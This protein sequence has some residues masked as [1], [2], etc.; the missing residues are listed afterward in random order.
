MNIFICYAV[1]VDALSI[2]LDFVFTEAPQELHGLP[3]LCAIGS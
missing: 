3:L 1:V 2:I